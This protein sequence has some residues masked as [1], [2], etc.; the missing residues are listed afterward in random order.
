[1]IP[2]DLDYYAPEN[3]VE[4]VALFAELKAA[5]QEPLY[6]AG[7]TEIVTLCR[8]QVIKPTALIDLKGIREMITLEAD[9]D[10][11]ILGANLC[12]TVLAEQ[13]YY[14]LLAT[15]ARG[16][17]DRTVRNRLTLGGNICGNLP[18]REA[19]LPLLLSEADVIVDGPEGRRTE[20]LRRLFDKRLRLNKEEILVQV[21]IARNE[22]S[23]PGWSRRREK[24]GPVDYPLYHLAGVKKK[25]Q[26]ALAVSG[27]C[28]YPF[29]S[30]DLE[31][32]INDRTLQAQ[33]RA[34]QA[35]DLLPGP[36]RSDN[37]GSVDYRK[38]LWQKD[39]TAMLQEMEGAE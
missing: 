19:V 15:V 7:G 16:V 5:A 23:W 37:L 28:A 4:A 12:L 32:L 35:L 27:L 31:K 18:Y 24:H 26:T 36:V 22:L 33:S 13:N 38:A 21:V 34:E 30:E 14:P 3:T 1:M 10:K 6:Y 25:G 9:D 11:L 29:R 20:T 8:H 2:F 17:A 39:L